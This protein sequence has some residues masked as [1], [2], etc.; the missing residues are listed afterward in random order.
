MGLPVSP[1]IENIY[2]K[3]FETLAIPSSP[4]LIK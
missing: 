2:M 4:T 1:I 3:H